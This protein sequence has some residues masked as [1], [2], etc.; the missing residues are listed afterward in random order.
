MRRSPGAPCPCKT[1]G[2]RKAYGDCCWHKKDHF[3]DDASGE[4]QSTVVIT[5]PEAIRAQHLHA[6]MLKQDP[7]AAGLP[8]TASTPLWGHKYDE[9]GRLTGEVMTAQEFH[10][11]K[12]ESLRDMAQ[13]GTMPAPLAQTG[14]MP[15]PLAQALAAGGM[16]AE[17]YVEIVAEIC[18]GECGKD[19]NWRPDHHQIP[20]P[21]LLLRVKEWN[22]ALATVAASCGLSSN[23]MQ[24]YHASPLAPCAF[25]ACAKMELKVKGHKLCTRCRKT[26]YCSRACHVSHYKQGHKAVCFDLT[27]CAP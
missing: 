22:A 2:R 17:I 18:G 12:M 6:Q 25:P 26:A 19:F 23:S 14:T 4:V 16:E 21:E 5:D 24:P 9:Q 27:A 13:T 1:K 7:E 20:K 15:A 10:E 8:L 11:E 3:Y